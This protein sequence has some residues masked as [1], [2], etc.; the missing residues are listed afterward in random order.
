VDLGDL[1]DDLIEAGE[2]EPVELD[3]ADWPIAAHGQSDGRADDSGFGKGGV[4]DP[5]FTEVLLQAVGDAEDAAELAD[6][7]A[8]DDRLGVV[9]EN[10]AQSLVERL[11]KR[12]HRHER[13][14]EGAHCWSATRRSAGST[15]MSGPPSA[16]C[17]T[18]GG[19]RHAVGR[20]GRDD[21]RKA[22]S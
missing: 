16:R 6:V 15:V 14:S 4:E 5:S 21:G 11:G 17:S 18:G 2:D 22:V 3:L 19:L 10:F 13:T 7:L 20:T 8:H 1:I 12:Q 9:L